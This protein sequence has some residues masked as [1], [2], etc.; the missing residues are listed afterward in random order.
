MTDS[1]QL[2]PTG[3]WYVSSFHKK[4]D[5]VN[6]V[7]VVEKIEYTD[8]SGNKTYKDNLHW[9]YDPQRVFYVTQPGWR[10]YKYKK[11]IG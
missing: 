6:V 8:A 7:G 3:R 9:Y 4:K 1:N 10:N 5:D 2:K 11:E